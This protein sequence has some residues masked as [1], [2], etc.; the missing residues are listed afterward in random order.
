V[1]IKI[2]DKYTCFQ[3]ITVKYLTIDWP[4]GRTEKVGQ[5]ERVSTMSTSVFLQ[6]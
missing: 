1:Q 2:N 6:F 5:K 4:L 3:P